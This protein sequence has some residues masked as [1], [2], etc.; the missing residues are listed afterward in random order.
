M[1]VFAYE[2]VDVRQ[3]TVNGL[4]TADT[5]RRAREL[6]RQRGCAVQKIALRRPRRLLPLWSSIPLRPRRSHASKA[7]S[8][9]RGLSTLLAVGVPLLEALDTL[10]RQYR[11]AF[12]ALVL[13][14]RERI[15][16]GASLAEAFAEHPT[17]FDELCV[18]VTGVGEDCGTLDEALQRLAQSKERSAQLKG[19]IA[20][21]LLYPVIVLIMAISISVFLMSF[22]VPSI[23][24][25]LLDLGQ[26]LPLPT[27]MVKATSDLLVNWGW[28]MAILVFLS[29]I[30]FAALVRTST[31]SWIWH[32][33]LLRLPILGEL[34]RKQAVVRIAVLMAVLLRSGVVF[35]RAIHIAQ[36]ATRNV[37]MRDALLRCEKAV[38]AGQ[39]IAAALE[40][41]G[42]FSALVVQVFA[43][44]QQSGRL[45]EMLER[46]AEN[47]D[48]DVATACGRLTAILEPVLV[49][50]LAVLVL[51][52]ALATMLP[53]LEASNVLG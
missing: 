48:Q 37:V 19:K 40:H 32:L 30:L 5:P 17:V 41:T 6:L 11:G 25:P 16:S 2:A 42:A 29:A 31:G 22:V 51:L 38:G 36:R 49:I 47:Y 28:L 46:L 1:P 14:L 45:E 21:S 34:L 8:L 35:V 50:I 44:G 15:A 26:P 9:L 10:S 39:D 12:Q 52:I 13:Q 24:E 7:L 20:T 18:T 23:L 43:V 53:I 33:T 27:R 4:I 3:T